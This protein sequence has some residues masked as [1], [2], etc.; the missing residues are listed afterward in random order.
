MVLRIPDDRFGDSLFSFVQALVKIADVSY[1]SREQVRSTF[2]EDFKAF[3]AET[4]PE[5]RYSFDWHDTELDPQMKYPVDCRLN[6][7][8]CPLFVYALLNDDRTN[9]ATIA[10]LTFEKWGLKF[11]SMGIFEDQASINRLVL[12]RFT[13]VCE[14]QFS[15]LG[16]NRN[17]IEKYIRDALR[18][19]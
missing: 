10:M 13:D 16:T 5:E 8:E 19:Q 4:V 18:L 12:A 15:S 2:L 7:M 6:G 9:Y 17:R 11:R 1:L 14:K 3:V